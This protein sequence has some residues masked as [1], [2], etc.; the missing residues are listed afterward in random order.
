VIP[1]SS[2]AWR[3][4]IRLR[5]FWCV[6]AC[7]LSL[8]RVHATS[9]EPCPASFPVQ[10]PISP[11]ERLAEADRLSGL[12]EV[13]KERADYFAYRGV[14]LLVLRQTQQAANALEKAIM[15][16]PDLAGTQLDYAQAL[17]ELG[18]LDPA[19]HLAHEV[20][21]RSDVPPAL[22]D[23]LWER[24]GQ[25]EQ[26]TWTREWS[27]RWLV[28]GESNLN[29]ASNLNT[30]ILTLPGGDIPVALA[31]SEH[32]RGG[33]A[34]RL[35]LAG[36]ASRPV[37]NGLLLMSGEV[38][39][40]GSSG[41]SDTNQRMVGAN[42]AYF[43]TL[44]FG[45][46]GLRLA[47]IRLAIGSEEVYAGRGWSLLYMLPE[48][49]SP[50]NCRVNLGRDQE[51]RGFPASPVLDGE[52]IGYQASL[53]CR[54][55]GWHWSLGLQSGLDRPQDVARLGGEQRRDSLSLGVGRG[56]G[57]GRLSVA[58]QI[59]RQTDRDLYSALLGGVAREVNRSSGRITYEYPVTK[60]VLVTAYCEK[61]SQNANIS[62]FNIE[63]KALYFGLRYHGP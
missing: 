35:D 10:P 28:G 24:L 33:N 44:P 40:R 4:L 47:G 43:H 27:A 46:M 60:Q 1:G 29:S 37:G 52:Y 62:L 56:V 42:A 51:S 39:A 53:N 50:S 21:R 13:C 45:Q 8:G 11:A 49:M 31:P 25:L 36:I 55:G 6:L 23:W 19:R 41:N 32:R 7:C 26:A 54:E 9:L 48:G 15:L 57:A 22:K 14:V 3:P 2:V 18:E 34:Q 61:T 38:S 20:S 17:A 16:D 30:L 58:A 63:N 5:V 12:G 59:D